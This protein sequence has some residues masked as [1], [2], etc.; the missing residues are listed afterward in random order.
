MKLAALIK[1]IEQALE[2][3][4]PSP[5][6]YI[7]LAQKISDLADMVGWAN[8][9]IDPNGQLADRL[10]S[11]MESLRSH[12][13]QTGED[14]IAALHDCVA[15]LSETIH[16]HDQDLLTTRNAEDDYEEL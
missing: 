3:N 1:D 12:H 10:D 9:P 5:N 6:E 8:G 7:G 16:Q 2:R 14:S 15:G 11:L 4:D 13:E